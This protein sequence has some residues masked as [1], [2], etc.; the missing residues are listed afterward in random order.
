M[1]SIY[2]NWNANSLSRA[3][4]EVRMTADGG[5]FCASV[6]VLF[7]IFYVSFSSLHD[8]NLQF[9]FDSASKTFTTIEKVFRRN[10]TGRILQKYLKAFKTG[11]RPK[12]CAELSKKFFKVF[13]R[14]SFIRILVSL[15]NF[16]FWIIVACNLIV[17]RK[18]ILSQF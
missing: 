14:D 2:G 18:D 5:K 11:L 15:V 17:F 8:S 10:I 7:A 4:N 6:S 13:F 9:S 3:E 12:K 16:F 1:N